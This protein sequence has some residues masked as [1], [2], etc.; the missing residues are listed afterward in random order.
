MRGEDAWV[1]RRVKKKFGSNGE[2]FGLVTA[3]EEWRGHPGQRVFK[4]VYT[5]G[6][7]EWIG[8]QDVHEILLSEEELV[9]QAAIV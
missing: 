3:V 7:S 2:F 5:D 9:S 4:V 8:V 6:D 1:G